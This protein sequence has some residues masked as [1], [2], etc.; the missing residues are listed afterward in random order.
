MAKISY[1]NGEKVLSFFFS[2]TL[3]KYVII[4]GYKTYRLSSDELSNYTIEE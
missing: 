2:T 4:T 1:I 3:N